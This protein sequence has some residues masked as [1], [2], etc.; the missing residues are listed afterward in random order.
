M[1]IYRL[2]E[3]DELLGD[4]FT[5]NGSDFLIA[6]GKYIQA[7]GGVTTAAEKSG[8]RRE[9]LYRML[10]KKSDTRFATFQAVIKSLEFTL[11]L[12]PQ[13]GVTRQREMVA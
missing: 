8:I 2:E 6:L 7:N 5:D 13:T 12:K 9:V 3:I 11:E 4:A 1:S 10:S